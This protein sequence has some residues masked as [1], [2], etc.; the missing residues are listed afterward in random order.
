MRTF[1]LKKCPRVHGIHFAPDGKRLLAVGGKEVRMVDCAVWLDLATGENVDRIEQFANCYAVDPLLTRYVLG[2]ADNWDGSA[3]VEW[4]DLPDG[5]EEWDTFE[6]RRR[7]APDFEEVSGLAFDRTGKRLAISHARPSGRRANP[8]ELVPHLTVVQRDSANDPLELP[9]QE[10]D[11]VLAFNINGTRLAA[12]GGIDCDP[13]VFVY[14]LATQ[15]ELFKYDPPGTITRCVRFLSDNRL[16][17][18]NGRYVYI[19]PPDGGEAQFTLSSHPMQMNAVTLTPDGK[20][21]LTASH[22]G[23][24]RV[25]DVNTGEAGPAFDWKIGAITAVAFAPDGL[26]CAAA[27]GK[28]QIVVW[29]VDE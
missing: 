26:T 7:K 14:D 9:T 29:D 12:T 16:V 5:G 20:R 28:G 18:A 23:M 27:G 3:G 19:V 2:G 11:S 13:R 17:V 8:H 25:W 22:D 1:K 15:R 6:F 21:L 24:V 10:Q 4:T